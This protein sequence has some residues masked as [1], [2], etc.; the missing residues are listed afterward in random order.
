MIEQRDPSIDFFRF[1]GITAII[2]AHSDIAKIYFQLRN[3]DVPLMVFISGYSAYHFSTHSEN[4]AFYV[5]DRFLRLV[6]PTWIF[7]T[8]Y[9]AIRET[10]GDGVATSK[11]IESYLM[12]GGPVG[13]WIIRIFFFMS[14]LTPFMIRLVKI[15][16]NY[17]T[18]LLSIIIILVLSEI[19]SEY[20]KGLP[21][22]RTIPVRLVFIFL[23]YNCSYG[24]VLYFGMIWG[25]FRKNG[26]ILFT[27]TWLICFL[28]FAAYLFFQNDEFVWTQ[29]FKNPPML[30]YLSYA[31]L[32]S[33]FLMLI[34]DTRLIQALSKNSFTSFIGSHPLWIYLWHWL[35]LYGYDKFF[36]F[37]DWWLYKFAI[38]Y[39]GA[40]LVTLLQVEIYRQIS[41]AIPSNYETAARKI[42]L[43]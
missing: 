36:P 43:G 37:D 40:I 13:V 17:F 19:I 20:F 25:K 31:L 41:P 28:S 22:P 2:L 12:T 8:L 4:L 39:F 18:L 15:D 27:L 29:K 3:F 34:K 1:I 10:L 24:I 7:L 21:R 5:K 26:Q 14:I 32:V 35:F 6:I 16:F 9:L 42:F 11:I 33:S 30:Y 38:S 23:L